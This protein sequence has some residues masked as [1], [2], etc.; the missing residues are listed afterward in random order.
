MGQSNIYQYTLHISKLDLSHVL[1]IPKQSSQSAQSSPNSTAEL[2]PP[3]SS[4]DWLSV[5]KTRSS[6]D[7]QCGTAGAGFGDDQ[8]GYARRFL[9]SKFQASCHVYNDG[10]AAMLDLT[11]QFVTRLGFRRSLF[12]RDGDELGKCNAWLS[13]HTVSNHGIG[14]VL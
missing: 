10:D 11:E 13:L 6:Q 1:M 14:L 9:C 4:D 7:L 2:P 8:N 12:L 3:T 5:P